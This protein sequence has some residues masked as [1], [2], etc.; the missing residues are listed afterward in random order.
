MRDITS[1]SPIS[2]TPS[3]SSSFLFS[4]VALLS[5]TL[6]KLTIEG[7]DR[8]SGILGILMG[9]GGGGGG[10]GMA[11]I[12]SGSNPNSSRIQF[13]KWPDVESRGNFG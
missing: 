4:V 8:G 3:K 7:T 9:T 13:Q 5:S 10:S 1:E 2:D 12:S 11:I 6:V